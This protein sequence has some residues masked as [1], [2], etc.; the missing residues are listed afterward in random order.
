MG[1]TSLIGTC[2]ALTFSLALPPQAVSQHLIEA[3]GADTEYRYLDWNYTWRNGP[4]VDLF[5]VGVPGSN[6]INLGGGY[7]FKRGHLMVAPLAYAV[8][9]HEHSQRGVKL[10]LLVTFEDRGWKLLA[11]VG[12][13]LPVSGG[14]DGYLVMDAFDLT[15]TI[16]TRWEAGVQSGFF[17]VDGAWN[18]QIGPLLKRNDGQG[19][20][21]V[22]YRFGTENEFRVGR[23]V[24]F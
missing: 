18:Q 24:V 19:A 8:I 3:R 1:R 21:A 12:R 13:Y 15:R 23:V 17:R 11:F 9:G 7:S 2:L 6:E 14:V 16:G 4:V 5:Y 22:S 10:A 20:W